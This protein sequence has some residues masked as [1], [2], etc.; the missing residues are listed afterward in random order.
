MPFMY[1]LYNCRAHVRSVLRVGSVCACWVHSVHAPVRS[2]HM[3]THTHTTH[4]RASTAC[5][6]YMTVVNLICTN[7][8]QGLDLF[9][10][11]HFALSR[12]AAG[13]GFAKYQHYIAD[14][15][16]GVELCI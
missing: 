12:S 7:G 15:P 5:T 6:V 3:H 14:I 9:C 10:S 8:D 1:I 13:S 16:T 2:T 11:S 4:A